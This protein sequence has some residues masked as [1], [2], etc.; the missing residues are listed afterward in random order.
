MSKE[1][2]FSTPYLPPI[3]EYNL[4]IQKI[5]NNKCLAT[6]GPLHSLFESKLC[7]YLHSEDLLLYSNGHTALEAIVGAMELK[8]EIITTPFT[9]IS[10]SNAIARN[11][12]TPVFCDINDNLTINTD[13]IEE[14]ISSNTVA[15]IAVHALG[16]V[17]DIERLSI[18]EKKYNVPV[19]YDGAHAFGI[20]VNGKSIAQYGTT[21]FSFH[22]SK[23]FNSAEG[24][25]VA[26]NNRLVAER[27][28]KYRFYGLEAGDV[29]LPGING[30]MNEL[31][32]ALG[33]CNLNHIDEIISYRKRLVERYKINLSSINGITFRKVDCKVQYNYIYFYIIVDEYK[34]GK[35]ADDLCNILNANK[36]HAKK[37]FPR[38]ISEMAFYKKC[39]KRSLDKASFYLNHIV[40]LPLHNQMNDEDVDYICDIIRH[41]DVIIN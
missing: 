3:E 41:K 14:M 34:Y 12:S 1:I 38:L 23:V 19:I 25:A 11:G 22:A 20:K 10:T 21:M 39:V 15:I 36:I 9:F 28:K 24:G 2:Y 32:A 6:F 27:I 16:N 31:S 37:C 26:C 8:G 7:E 5:W 33:L 13:Q 40:V 35:T 4:Q 17:C 29:N 18:I 30:K